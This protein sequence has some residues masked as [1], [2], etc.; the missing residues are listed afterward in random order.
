MLFPARQKNG[1][2]VKVSWSA[3]MS[4]KLFV[5]GLPGSGKSTVARY[6]VE[7][8]KRHYDDFHAIR[9]C[10]YDILYN[11]FKED[12]AEEH[13]YPTEHNG[14]CVKNPLCYDEALKKFEIEINNSHFADNEI[15]LLEFARNDYLHA[16]QNFSI[17]FLHDAY[18][19][20]LD[21]DIELGMKRVKERVR[22]PQCSDDHF[23][24]KYTFEFYRQK[25]N[26]KYLSSVAKQLSIK[27]GIN[28][29]HIKIVDNKGPQRNYWSV[30]NEL[31]NTIVNEAHILI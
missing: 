11:M 17:T 18:F 22:H 12:D 14:F 25:D 8:V 19:L 13:F 27:Y 30:V 5:L 2:V 21:V 20:L 1:Y 23:V 29:H 24:S 7:N 9:F 16:F 3:F 28:P 4:Q 31:I 15:A 10:D 26:A 6:I